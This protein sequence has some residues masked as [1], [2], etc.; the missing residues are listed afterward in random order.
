MSFMQDAHNSVSAVA[1]ERFALQDKCCVVTGGTKGI[2][3]AIVNELAKLGAK[4]VTCSRKSDELTTC[5]QE[6]QKQGLDVQG[7]TADVSTESGRSDLLA[8]VQ[9]VFGS[10]LD[11]LVHNV[12]TNIRKPTIEYSDDDYQQIMS[13]NLE[14]TYKL[15]QKA[16]PLLKEAGSAKMVLISSVAGGPIAMKSGTLYAMTKAAMNQLTK[17]L[18]CEWGPDGIHV[19]AVSPWYILTP[20][21]Q[22][23]LQ[24]DEY[25]AKVLSRTPLKR[26][27][28]PHEVSGVVAFLCGPAGDYITGQNIA[29]D[30]GYSVMGFY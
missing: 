21:A 8:K 24:D 25:K 4:V 11:V 20:L 26:V 29:V 5:L 14:S 17:N 10:K 23:V 28:Q 13:A 6:W 15:S 19:N 9:D 27:G 2:G 12:G 1:V 3:F 18:C 7:C 30:G 16:Y 22:Q